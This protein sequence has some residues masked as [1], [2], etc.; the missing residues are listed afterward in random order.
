[1][2]SSPLDASA[3]SLWDE[4]GR[5][6]IDLLGVTWQQFPSTCAQPDEQRP[7]LTITSPL[8]GT[9]I[10]TIPRLGTRDIRAATKR[11]RA[12]QRRWT[13]LNVRERCRRLLAFHDLVWKYCD[14][15]ADLV[16]WESGKARA[17]AFEEIADVAMT[18]RYLA[19][20]APQTLRSRTVAGTLPL[21]TRTTV[22]HRPKGVVAVIAPWNYPLTLVASDACAALVAGNAVLLKPDSHTPFTALA[23]RSLFERCGLDPDLFQV[24][25]GS[26][27]EVGGELVDSADFVMFTGS[28]AT[29]VQIA[30]RAAAHLRGVSLELGG[31]NPM[32]VCS[33][34]PLSRTIP[35][36]VKAC[37][38][39]AGQL[40]VSIERIYVV[41]EIWDRFVP[42]F[43]DAVQA[44]RVEASMNWQASMGP[45]I[46]SEHAQR[47]HAHVVDAVEKGARLHVGGSYRPDVAP[48]AYAP[49]VL[50]GVTA[51]MTVFAQETFGPVVS[52]YRV[53]DEDEAVALANASSYGLNASVWTKNLRRGR[54]IAS[55][56]ECGT[57][58]I[59]EG[60]VAAWASQAAPMGGMK[61]SGIGR[62]HG[63][64][65][66]TK[67]T[68]P[69]TIAT[70]RLMNI[71]APNTIGEERWATVMSL[72]LRML[73]TFG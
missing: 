70:Q 24:L 57:V 61:S 32:I 46:S 43:V 3:A 55:R 45:L 7:P 68:E 35:G 9:I 69:Q 17:H 2:K 53:R 58:N 48:S 13:S 5:R 47:V 22:H 20:H 54:D 8:T 37:F 16:Q 1:M 15:L 41:S 10:G 67:Y 21:L 33:D 11:A 56:L 14:P 44:L 40:C 72:W 71:Q 65:G 30:T 19:R 73:R 60:Y 28:T 39:N 49:T 27:A 42:A 50:S 52:L 59:N 26:G 18:A 6:A 12:A 34:A 31:K 36:A 38:S 29:G 66:I 64:E 51:D 62:R 23:V 4:R 25:P 63:R